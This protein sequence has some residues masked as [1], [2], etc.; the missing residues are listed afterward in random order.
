MPKRKSH[1]LSEVMAILPEKDKIVLTKI[2]ADLRKVYFD[3]PDEALLIE[4]ALTRLDM[5]RARIRLERGHIQKIKNE[6][7]EAQGEN[8][9]RIADELEKC[10]SK[11]AKIAG[12]EHA[13]AKIYPSMIRQI[14]FDLE[15]IA[16]DNKFSEYLISNLDK[17]IESGVISDVV[18]RA[19]KGG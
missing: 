18:D 5:H 10:A 19:L 2:L 1:T 9:K 12:F 17:L 13:A 14:P 15:K 11:L 6:N 16:R 3:L 4:M 7:A 8:C